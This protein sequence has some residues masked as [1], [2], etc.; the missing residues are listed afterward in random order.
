M[1]PSKRSKHVSPGELREKIAQMLL[2]GFR[3][4]EI[5]RDSSIARD[6]RER[7]LGGV[8]LFDE[9]CADLSTKSRNIQSPAQ[10][11][12]LVTQIRTCAGAPPLIAI[13]QEGGWVNRLKPR[14][15]F[16]PTTSAADLGAAND[17]GQTFV[18][19]SAIARNLAGLGI[20]LNLAPVLD[21]D[22]KSEQSI[23]SA[24]R[25]SFSSEAETVARHALEFCRA[26]REHGVLVC[27][28]HF[29]GHGSARGD[30]HL[31][32]VEITDTWSEAE[33]VP[34]QR[35]I[36]RNGCQLI[37]TAHVI[38]RRLDP[39]WPATLSKP[40]VTGLLRE[41]LGFQGIVMSDDMQMGAISRNY[42]MAIALERAINAGIDLLCFANN[43]EFDS[44]IATKAIDL[45]V[46]LVEQGRIAESRIEESFLRIQKLK[47]NAPTSAR[48][49]LRQ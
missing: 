41:R 12:T 22:A 27:G 18:Q 20:N 1:T 33:L 15:G 14:L 32:L 34:Y 8:I 11:T 38:H 3:G 49:T 28:K 29:P 13:D 37:M 42:G 10:L 46:D 43:S 5:D 35:L 2:I 6:L 21:L 25:R 23:I 45:I 4:L 16:P 31:G 39:E 44:D 17:L 9:E 40:V 24:K 36:E 48:T 19:A 7:N 30:T 26:H 47:A